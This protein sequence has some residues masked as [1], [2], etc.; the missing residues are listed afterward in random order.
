MGIA[1]TSITLNTPNLQNMV[2]FYEILG[3]QFNKVK[4]SVG[5][6][7]FRSVLKEFE[8]SLMSIPSAELTKNPKVMMGF[9]VQDLD[10]K[11]A[12]LSMIP[13]VIVILEPTLM[14]DGK[15]AIVLDPDG[16]SIE[17]LEK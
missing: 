15:K 13:G 16:Q 2:R 7:L 6:E 12:G 1:F 10:K 4:I 9:R 14:A 3:C 17:L 8:L 11:I 5:G